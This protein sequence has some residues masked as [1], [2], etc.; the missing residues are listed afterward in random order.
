MAVVSFVSPPSP[1]SL[2]RPTWQLTMLCSIVRSLVD[3]TKTQTYKI[4]KPLAPHQDTIYLRTS[5]KHHYCRQLISPF[6]SSTSPR[7]KRCSGG[8][9]SGQNLFISAFSCHSS[10]PKGIMRNR[11]QKWKGI[12][13]FFYPILGTNSSSD[14]NESKSIRLS[15]RYIDHWGDL[16]QTHDVGRF[17]PRAIIKR[18]KYRRG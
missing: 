17:S 3:D 2:N 8:A 7:E 13:R 10:A 18:C 15:R 4:L 9:S 12:N 1:F 11:F 6:L 16:N 14:G 5:K